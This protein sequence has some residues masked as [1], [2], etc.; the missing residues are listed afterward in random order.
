MQ[1]PDAAQVDVAR[2]DVDQLRLV[3]DQGDARAQAELGARYEDGR[4][5]VQDYVAA[6]SWFRRAA[7]QG[8]APGQAALGFLYNTGRG[9]VRSDRVAVSWHRR[10]AEQGNARAQ[11]NLGIVYRDGRG[12]SRDE[13][14]AVRWFRRA[15]EQ[16]NG[17]A[18]NS[19][20]DMY[21][22]GRGVSRDDE[23]AA[24]WFRQAAEQG[25]D[26]AQTN[27]GF[28]YDRGRGVPQDDAEALKMVSPGGRTGPPPGAVQPGRHVLERP[29]HAPGYRG[30]CPV[31]PSGRRTG[32]RRSAGVGRSQQ[33]LNLRTKEDASCTCTA[34][35]P[36]DCPDDW[37]V[38]PQVGRGVCRDAPPVP[39]S[40]DQAPA[41]GTS[42]QAVTPTSLAAT[43]DIPSR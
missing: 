43:A 36:P 30:S 41:L 2:L 35:A 26:F 23:E 14:E 1:P 11:N 12:I 40:F 21:R 16:G 34:S 13:R 10:A 17:F 31:V 4:G 3:A 15:A 37:P 18:Q 8:Y 39:L 19:L 9:V 29:R 20:G 5:V 32:P 22:D 42:N 25:H 38:L 24:R 28:M 27:L 7:E 33:S 6:V